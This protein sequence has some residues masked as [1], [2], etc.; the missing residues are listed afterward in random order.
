MLTPGIHIQHSFCDW[1]VSMALQAG[2]ILGQ[3]WVGGAQELLGVTPMCKS[4]DCRWLDRH[5]STAV[6]GGGEDW[7]VQRGWELLEGCQGNH[8]CAPSHWPLCHG[9]SELWAARVTE[10]VAPAV[11]L[12]NHSTALALP[13]GRELPWDQ[14]SDY[15]TMFKCQSCLSCL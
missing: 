9:D 11:G 15:K 13:G 4:H 10:Q 8:G 3:P 5:S 7:S 12:A 14:F 2:Q 6:G 1:P